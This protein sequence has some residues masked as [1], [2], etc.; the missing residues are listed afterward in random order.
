MEGSESS[1][2]RRSQR[3][4]FQASGGKRGARLAVRRKVRLL[5]LMPPRSPSLCVEGFGLGSRPPSRGE[6]RGSA[7]SRAG[8]CPPPTPWGVCRCSPCCGEPAARC[9]VRAGIYPSTSPS[10]PHVRATLT[11]RIPCQ[12]LSWCKSTARH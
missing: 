7:G 2:L 3:K 6:G 4:G 9:A 10:P 12:P 5:L 1:Q 11:G 8:V